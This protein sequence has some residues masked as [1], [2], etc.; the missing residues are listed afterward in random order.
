M[1]LRSDV[2]CDLEQPSVAG[3]GPRP[4]AKSSPAHPDP[5]R[6]CIRTPSL[7]RWDRRCWE[8][9]PAP[10]SPSAAPWQGPQGRVY[11]WRSAW[12]P[13]PGLQRLSVQSY[14]FI[15]FVFNR[16]MFPA[17]PTLSWAGFGNHFQMGNNFRGE[18]QL[19]LW[20]ML[21]PAPRPQPWNCPEVGGPACVRE[22][23]RDGLLRLDVSPG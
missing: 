12:P 6:P 3:Q 8:K 20:P 17:P 4:Q 22:R 18:E 23:S 11:S 21:P 13:E 10:F 14:F 5:P 19:K 7:P 16:K 2:L 15:S 9:S 1:P